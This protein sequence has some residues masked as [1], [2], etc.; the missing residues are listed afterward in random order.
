MF[1]L[2]I[3]LLTAFVNLPALAAGSTVN[4]VVTSAF[5]SQQ[6]LPVYNQLAQY[7]SAKLGRKVQVV[8]DVSYTDADQLLDRGIIQVGFVCGMPYTHKSAEGKYILLAIPVMSTTTG[9]FADVTSG[10]EKTPGKYYSYTIVRKSSP[11]RKW[12]DLKGKTYTFN[13]VTS[14]SGYNM[15]RYK[16]VKMGVS[17]WE[18]FFSKV[19]VSGSHEESI[20]LVSRGVVDASS[21]DSMVLDYDR[22]IG[23][24]DALNVRVIEQLFPG[25]AGA[26]PVVIS[27]RAD[28]SLRQPL[29]SALVNMHK[30]PEGKKIL[31]KALL[32]RFDPANDA[33]YDDI[34]YMKAA[35]A[36]AGF[37][38]YVQK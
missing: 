12:A 32:L 19:V 28:P 17:S 35:A 23:D 13:D 9:R 31:A 27:A 4:I 34:R 25:G 5:V 1:R 15:P 26:P 6:G 11:F 30:D 14:N 21:V 37:R 20:R 33:N 36:T 24:V 2:L 16:L 18:D 29:Q 7:L 10:Y 38:D 8:S 3:L 22:S